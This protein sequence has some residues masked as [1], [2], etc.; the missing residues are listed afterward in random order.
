MEK[1]EVERCPFDRNIMKL[2]DLTQ[3]VNGIHYKSEGYKCPK[4]GFSIFTIKQ[5]EK[6]HQ[7]YLHLKNKR[8]APGRIRENITV[9][10]HYRNL[11][12]KASKSHSS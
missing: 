5:A 2:A 10:G 6:A 8:K 3:N 7:K 9:R 12:K 1:A 4:C 11:P